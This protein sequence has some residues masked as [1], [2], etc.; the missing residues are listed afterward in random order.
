MRLPEGSPRPPLLR[1]QL[2]DEATAG[3]KGA[4]CSTEGRLDGAEGSTLVRLDHVV[5]RQLR[6]G[7]QFERVR[8]LAAKY[9]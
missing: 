5:T 3:V 6:R 7:R 4:L 1:V 2:H 9:A 8:Q